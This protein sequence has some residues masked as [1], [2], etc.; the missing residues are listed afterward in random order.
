MKSLY[1]NGDNT[2]ATTREDGWLIAKELYPGLSAQSAEDG[3]RDSDVL[4][5]VAQYN[6]RVSAISARSRTGIRHSPVR[7]VEP[8]SLSAGYCIE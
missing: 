4:L 1:V 2:I 6:I 5:I 3:T 8:C 7:F